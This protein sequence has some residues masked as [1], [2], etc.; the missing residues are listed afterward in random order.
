MEIKLKPTKTHK[1]SYIR[2]KVVNYLK[3]RRI[4]YATFATANYPDIII[5]FNGACILIEFKAYIN[6]SYKVTS[7]QTQIINKLKK[8]SINVIVMDNN[9]D[10]ETILNMRL[11]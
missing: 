6:G 2:T 1:E 7:G 3:K 8:Q 10:Y 4:M 5:F 9:S 11:S